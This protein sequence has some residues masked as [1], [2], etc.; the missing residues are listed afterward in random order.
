MGHPP[1][2]F[3]DI[4]AVIVVVT[5]GLSALCCASPVGE[6]RGAPT[7]RQPESEEIEFETV[8]VGV[9][10]RKDGGSISFQVFKSRD[11]VVVEWNVE[12]YA[13]SLRAQEEIN[14]MIDRASTVEERGPKLDPRG[15]KVGERAVLLKARGTTKEAYIVWTDGPLVQYLWSTS[16]RHAKAYEKKRFR[17]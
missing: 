4:I 7:Q 5:V 1:L 15:R 16:L 2:S 12:R 14:K 10:G 17:H 11:G 3:V 8:L 6:T 13:S 9:K